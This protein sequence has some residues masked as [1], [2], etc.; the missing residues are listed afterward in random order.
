MQTQRLKVR[1]PSE[2]LSCVRVH[3]ES[4]DSRAEVRDSGGESVDD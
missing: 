3:P 4:E 1:L 2:Q